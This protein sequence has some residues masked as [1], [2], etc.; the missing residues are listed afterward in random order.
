MSGLPP[1]NDPARDAAEKKALEARDRTGQVVGA[2]KDG[3]LPSTAQITKTID[4]IQNSDELHNAGQGVTPLGKRVLADTEKLLESTKRVLEEKNAGNQ[5]QNIV[6]HGVQGAKDINDNTSIPGDFK[7]KVRTETSAAQRDA[8]QTAQSAYQ[9]ILRI[10]SLVMSSPEFR[11]LLNDLNSIAQEV[12]S[13]NLPNQSDNQ[14]DYDNNNNI[15]TQGSH[16]QDPDQTKM[17]IQQNAR[18]TADRTSQTLREN[19]YPLAK[20]VANVG[21]EHIRDFSEGKKSLK[22]ATT[23]GVKSLQSSVQQN[24]SVRKLSDEERDRLVNRFKNVMIEAHRNQQYQDAISELM[25]LISQLSQQTQE[26]TQHLSDNL[27]G[28]REEINKNDSIQ[29]ATKNARDI[30]EKFANQSLDPLIDSIRE[31][32]RQMKNDQELRDYFKEVRQFIGKSLHDTEFVQNTDYTQYGSELITT[33]RQILLEKYREQSE[34]VRRQANSFNEA[35]QNDPTTAQWRRDLDNLVTDL[36]LDESGSPTIKYELIKDAAK[37]IPV[38]TTQLQYLPLPRIENSDDEYD[39][40]F[41]NMVLHL[42]EILPS[43]AHLTLTSDINLDRE[44]TS[45]IKNYAFF[46]V[47]KIR[48]DARNI[49]FYYKKKKGVINMNDLGLVDFSIPNNGLRFYLKLL[50]EAP[51]KD[52]PNLRF[53]VLE[54]DTTIE[55]LKLRIHQSKHDVLYKILTP[56]AQSKIKKQLEATITEKM[57][58]AVQ[59]L[60]DSIQRLQVQVSK[61]RQKSN[62][63]SNISN[64]TSNINTNIKGLAN[65]NIIGNAA[66]ILTGGNSNNNN[67]NAGYDQTNNNTYNDNNNNTGHDQNKETWRTKPIDPADNYYNIP[68]NNNN[69]KTDV[70]PR[71]VSPHDTTPQ[72]QP[73]EE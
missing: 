48:A 12:V 57:K 6:Y 23:G 52:H 15:V 54:A 60:Q 66:N 30:V 44:S 27:A 71:K 40:A 41:D 5:L 63:N 49:A 36:F 21:G 32:G 68:V 35:I 56:L 55:S 11:A 22:E 67:N 31:F 65:K 17:E 59:L 34:N 18:E 69:N 73:L 1:Q 10:P 26:L 19:A 47:S 14:N 37:I 58:E 25:D 61:L 64:L 4:K 45:L 3:K 38:L 43:H 16:A 50:L 46:E 51:T 62:I 53:N 8:S 39:F 28:P 33:G 2:L 29:I 24:V 7:Q 20:N 42:P 13:I 9:K 70:P 72:Y